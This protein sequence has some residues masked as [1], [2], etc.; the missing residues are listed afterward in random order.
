MTGSTAPPALAPIEPRNSVGSLS[1]TNGLTPQN[2]RVC[3]LYVLNIPDEVRFAIS[4]GLQKG[5]RSVRAKRATA[6]AAMK[7]LLT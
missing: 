7:S 4:F 3:S 6:D 5:L 1:H 2:P